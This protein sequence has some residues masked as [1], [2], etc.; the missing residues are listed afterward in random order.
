MDTLFSSEN[1]IDAVGLIPVPEKCW[2][3]HR[4]ARPTVSLRFHYSHIERRCRRVL[5]VVV[6]GYQYCPASH[7]KYY[8]HTTCN[9][10]LHTHSLLDRLGFFSRSV[11]GSSGSSSL[12]IYL[13]LSSTPHC[14]SCSQSVRMMML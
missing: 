5:Y 4:P 9:N 14:S 6:S 1:K 13:C 3:S 7:Q 12:N 10:T 2:Y 8:T 11:F